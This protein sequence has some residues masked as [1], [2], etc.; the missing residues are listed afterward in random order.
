MKWVD[1]HC[2]LEL[3]DYPD[4]TPFIERARAAGLVHAVVVGQMQKSGGSP[5][6]RSYAKP[7]ASRK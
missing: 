7:T 2:H 1:A 3:H 5:H 4:A 6:S